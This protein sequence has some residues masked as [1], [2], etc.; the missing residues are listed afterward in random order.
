MTT[1]SGCTP[2]QLR[3][4]HLIALAGNVTTPAHIIA[5]MGYNPNVVNTH[6][7][8]MQQAGLIHKAKGAIWLTMQGLEVSSQPVMIGVTHCQL[9]EFDRMCTLCEGKYYAQGYC[10]KHYKQKQRG[11]L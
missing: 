4:L 2:A 3:I 1:I 10:Q 5:K 6:L 8:H 11:K 9:V 7:C